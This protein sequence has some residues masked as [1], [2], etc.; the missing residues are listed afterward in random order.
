MDREEKAKAEIDLRTS[1]TSF[2]EK[3]ENLYNEDIVPH[4]SLESSSAARDSSYEERMLGKLKAHAPR[5]TRY[6]VQGKIAHGG[7]GTIYKVWDADL[8]RTLAMKVIRNKKKGDDLKE[9]G[10]PDSS[11]LVRFLEEAQITGQLDHPCIVPVHDLSLDENGSIYFTMHLVKGQ[12]LKTIFKW[13]KEGKDGWN[14]TRALDVFLHVLEAMAYAHSKGVIH[15]DLKPANVM[16]GRFGQVYVMDWGLAKI[17][18]RNGEH[19]PYRPRTQSESMSLIHT[20]LTEEQDSNPDALLL[21]MDGAVIGTPAYMPPE[22]ACGEMDKLDRR[23]DVYSVGAMLYHLLT[24]RMPYEQPGVGIGGCT[25]WRWVLEGPPKPVHELAPDVPAELEA[26]CEKAMARDP[27]DRY[28][29][30]M[31]M[32]EDLR[33]YL[34]NRVVRAHRSGPF[35]EFR[36]W[37]TRNRPLA[38]SL[39]L[40]LVLILGSTTVTSLVLA[41]KNREVTKARDDAQQAASQTGAINDFLVNE[42]LL[43]PTP[44]HAMGRKLAVE[45]VLDHAAIRI[46]A[47]LSGQKV[48]EASVRHTLGSAY[49]ALSR[50]D[51]GAAQLRKALE[52]R[53]AELGANHRDT[54]KTEGKVAWGLFKQGELD[55]ADNMLK[56]NWEKKR[57]SLGEEDEDTLSSGLNYASIAMFLGRHDEGEVIIRKTLEIRSRTLGPEHAETI[58]TL[59]NLASCIRKQGRLDEAEPIFREVLEKMRS[60][61]SEDHPRVLDVANDLAGLIHD[62]GDWDEAEALYRNCLERAIRIYGKEHPFYAMILNNLASVLED[63]DFFNQRSEH[64]KEAEE[65]YW[66]SLDVRRKVFDEDHPKVGIAI[67]NLARNLQLQGRNQEA[68]NMIQQAYELSLNKLGPDHHETLLR[69]FSM[70][71]MSWKLGDKDTCE[72]YLKEVVERGLRAMPEGHWHLGMWR[73][74]YG[75]ALWGLMKYPEAEQELLAAYDILSQ[76]LGHEH[77]QTQRAVS[78]LAGLYNSWE[79]PDQSTLWCEKLVKKDKNRAE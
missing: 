8:R 5:K 16:V 40:I 79:K 57:R 42:L 14:L 15:R 6:E 71:N 10:R 76:A 19:D 33:A 30:T 23:A 60:R 52:L 26:I 20:E 44:A 28:A 61:L 66:E 59:Y 48:V 70:G 63:R 18:D 7:M 72:A 22:Q 53:Q 56:A 34:E 39:A 29:D 50:Y 47:A 78:A 58:D 25:V 45:D 54:L 64:L 51:E 67:N 13:V 36:K 4:V 21:T 27:D 38:L 41:A 1:H 12:D 68:M 46:G 69:L 37:V 2:S 35:V 24:G 55:E 32:A 65:L 43:A 77:V 3:L 74:G 62:T 9:D 17:L 73:E 49:M 31:E 75:R 11:V